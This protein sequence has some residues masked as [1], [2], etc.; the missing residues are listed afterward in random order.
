MG[1]LRTLVEHFGALPEA[2]RAARLEAAGHLDEAL[3][4]YRKAG[5]QEAASRI[6]MARAEA[7]LDPSTKRTM[8]NLAEASASAESPTACSLRGRAA[9]LALR[10]THA[11]PARSS[12][13]EYLRIAVDLEAAGMPRDAAD[14]YALSGDT[15]NQARMLAACGAIDELEVA[16]EADRVNLTAQYRREQTWK[17]ILDLDAIGSRKAAVGKCR[18]W[19]DESPR[20]DDIAALARAIAQRLVRPGQLATE[21]DGARTVLIPDAEVTIGR[22]DASINVPSPA[23]SRRHLVI[24]PSSTG[25]IVFD[26]SSRNGTLLA[27]ARIAGPLPVGTGI[28]LM[29]GGQVPLHAAPWGSSGVALTLPGIAC[30]APL[31]PLHVGPFV[32]ERSNDIMQLR[33]SG[34][35]GA[36]ILNGLIAAPCVDLCYGDE[37]RERRDGPVLLKVLAP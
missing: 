22:S 26:A 29:L 18:D 34:S 8:L 21:I 33:P 7:E 14:A 1:W 25:P 4:A 16:L 10:S 11:A 30:I 28:D 17:E 5:L 12:R 35:N 2:R 13:T 27:G 23:L 19:L 36:P 3:A 6:L 32:I 37:I 20:D 15:E 9:L 24:R 31:G